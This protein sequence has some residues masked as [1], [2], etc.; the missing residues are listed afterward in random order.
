MS[1]FPPGWVWDDAEG[2]PVYRPSP[3]PVDAVV[4]IC[5]QVA[6]EVGR[7][8]AK[9]P[10]FNSGHEGWAVIKEELEE[11]WEQ[12]RANRSGSVTARDEAI[13]VAAMA[14]RFIYDLHDGDLT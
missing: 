14:V 2:R 12:V 3:V 10:P 1:E 13:Q 9:F 8:M 11:L 5:G 7:A 6:N 4:Y